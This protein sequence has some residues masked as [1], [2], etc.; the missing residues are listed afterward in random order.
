MIYYDKT[1]PNSNL[2]DIDRE[3]IS[4]AN[5]LKEKAQKLI[6]EN[7]D[8]AKDMN[9]LILYAKVA[10][11][12][13]IQKEESKFIYNEFKK[14][15][16]KMDLM[17]ELDRLKE[18]QLQENRE[19]TRK[20]QQKAGSLVIVDQIKERD[21]ERI[22]G[23]EMLERER[24]MILKQTKE[25]EEEFKRQAEIKKEQAARLAKE[26]DETNIKAIEIKE[27]KKIEEK[28]LE[29]RIHQYNLEKAKREEEELGEKR[30]VYFYFTTDAFR[31]KKKKKYRN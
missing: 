31:T 21:M 20:D 13:D 1:K 6:D 4:R 22:K 16:E 25:L 10:T 9:K 15:E 7:S 8:E 26:V 11:I 17:M 18:L 3:N 28:E 27:R 29:L 23:K 2:S 30:F 12:R 24:Q 14:Q 5:T 19:R